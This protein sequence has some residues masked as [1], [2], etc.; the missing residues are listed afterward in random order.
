LTLNQGQ[1]A[2]NGIRHFMLKAS[3]FCLKTVF[4]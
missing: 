4:L 2:S 3:D 1:Q